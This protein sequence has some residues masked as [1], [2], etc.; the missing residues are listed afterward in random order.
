MK[1]QAFLPSLLFGRQLR[2]KPY[3]DEFG[4]LK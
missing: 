4:K 2:E 1:I 3:V